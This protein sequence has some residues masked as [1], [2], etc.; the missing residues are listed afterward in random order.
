MSAAAPQDDTHG[1]FVAVGMAVWVSSVSDDC[2]QTG[3]IV[4]SAAGAAI[5]GMDGVGPVR[6]GAFLERVQIEDRAL[7]LNELGRGRGGSPLA[8]EFR[9]ERSGCGV[10]RL[11]LRAA[12]EPSADG[13]GLRAAGVLWDTLWD[14]PVSAGMA[15]DPHQ[16]ALALAAM[17]YGVIATDAAA[18]ITYMNPAAERLSGASCRTLLGQRIHQVLRFQHASGEAQRECA[19]Q[20]CLR[21]GHEIAGEAD[22]VLAT[23]DGRRVVIEEAAACIVG[24]DGVI[25]GAV[26]SIR[27]VSH[28]RKINQQ[29][30]WQATHDSLTG[31][32]NRSEFESRLDNACRTATSEGQQHALLFMDLDRFKIVN[33][34]CG[35]C[36]GDMLLQQLT[37]MLLAHMR[38]SD[39]LARLGG[40]ELGVLLLHCPPDKAQ[41]VAETLR[42]AVG[43][44]RFTWENHVFQLGISIGIAAVNADCPP[45][46]QILAEA[47]SACYLAKKGGRNCI[48]VHQADEATRLLREGKQQWLSTLTEAFIHDDF[49]LFAMPVVALRHGAAGHSEVLVRLRGAVGTVLLP[50]AFLP[51]AAR[52]DL[53][54]SIDRWVVGAVCRFLGERRFD[55][56]PDGAGD[57]GL[58][59]AIFAINLAHATLSD[60]SFASYVLARLAEFHVA[61]ACLCFEFDEAELN[62]A[63]DAVR[64]FVGALHGCGCTFS[65]DNFTGGVASFLHLKTLPV[66]TLTIH[67]DLV[68]AIPN[69]PLHRLLVASINDVAHAMGIRTVAGHVEDDAILAVIRAIGIDCAQGYAMGDARPLSAAFH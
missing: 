22:C 34:T 7:V 59:P 11:A 42:K 21:L 35:H 31:L 19:V 23:V 55:T 28:E 13:V 39:T 63:P 8:M 45:A 41:R 37:K 29:L 48:H 30:S 54:A 4:W 15:L 69:D 47:D 51:A 18:R 33:D 1:A 26:L 50:E 24:S 32:L 6:F 43:E 53:M 64:A 25:E 66:T 62:V 14:V 20:R 2:L 38:D 10:R 44:F 40:D 61:P 16:A 49:L 17:P 56:E 68:R 57:D 67:G 65:L 60:P 12:L 27:D 58:V 52:Y 36:A 46:V 3:L 9:F 5:T